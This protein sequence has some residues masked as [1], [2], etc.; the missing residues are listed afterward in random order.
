MADMEID[1][2]FISRGLK[3][4]LNIGTEEVEEE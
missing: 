3:K 4:A 1:T 2:G